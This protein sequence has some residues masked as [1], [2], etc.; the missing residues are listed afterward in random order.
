MECNVTRMGNSAEWH[1]VYYKVQTGVMEFIYPRVTS[2]G[3][4]MG[5]CERGWGFTK[6][7]KSDQC[8]NITG[9]NT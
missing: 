5:A 7:T 2:T 6:R 3:V 8:A 1:A 9:A 4:M